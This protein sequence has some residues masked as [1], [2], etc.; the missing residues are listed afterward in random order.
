[1]RSLKSIRKRIA[2]VRSTQKITKAMKM[3]A[4]ARLRRAQQR[5]FNSRPYA[6]RIEEL[7]GTVTALVPGHRMLRAPEEVSKAEFLILTSDR[8]LCGAFNG[9][10]L[11]EIEDTLRRA[12]FPY[13]EVKIHV[14]GKKGR[15]YFKARQRGLTSIETGLYE[16]FRFE[17]AYQ[18]AKN[19]LEGFLSGAADHFYIVYNRFKSAITQEIRIERILPLE[20]RPPAG[21]LPEYLYEP[22]RDQVVEELIPQGIAVRIYRAFLESMAGEFGARMTAMENATNNCADMI[23]RLTLQLNRARQAAITSE[24]MDIVNGAEALK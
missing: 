17:K 3:V 16:E 9:N 15:D 13:R 7:L 22:S 18:Y 21:Y 23:S 10:L 5:L 20:P 11:R 1:M 14:V 12:D 6:E 24:L 19:F 8:G 4:A 2:T